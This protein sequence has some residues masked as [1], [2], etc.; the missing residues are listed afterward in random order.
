MIF[1]DEVRDDDDDD[2]DDVGV[3]W[4]GGWIKSTGQLEQL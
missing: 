2:D 4:G 1:Y 3:V